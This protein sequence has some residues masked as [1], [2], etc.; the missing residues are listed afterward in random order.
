MT[1]HVK[2]GYTFYMT[3]HKPFLTLKASNPWWKR[4]REEVSF[5]SG[6]IEVENLTPM[7]LKNFVKLKAYDGN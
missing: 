7:H 4:R 2:L 3:R 5:V 1:C 6:Q